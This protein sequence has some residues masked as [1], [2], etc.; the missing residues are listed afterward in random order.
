MRPLEDDARRL[1]CRPNLAVV[2]KPGNVAIRIATIDDRPAVVSTVVA[3]FV[4][5][6]AF[7]HFFPDDAT[8]D[9]DATAFVEYL[10][11][12]RVAHGSVWVTSRCEAVALWSP[13]AASISDEQR[14]ASQ[15]RRLEMIAT[16]GPGAA[17]RL[18]HYDSVVDA[19]LPTDGEFW[20]LGILACHPDHAGSGLGR[21]VL[22]AGLSHVRFLGA[23]AYLETT[24]PAN[25]GYYRR[26]GWTEATRI[27]TAEPS[28]IWVLRAD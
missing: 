1:M 6:P 16:V 9:A 2:S 8:Y 12:K 18:D 19:A 3:A 27:Q 15:H 7:R 13:P 5:D 20:Y 21:H 26:A 24:N 28:T 25:V 17:A 22:D 23:S 11:D 4:A 10:F 14:L